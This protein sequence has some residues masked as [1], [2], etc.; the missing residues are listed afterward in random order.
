MTAQPQDKNNMTPAEYLAMERGSLD[1]KHEFFDGEIFA[2]VGAKINHVRI[3]A[4]LTGELRNHFK[5]N[6]SPCEVLPNDMRVK[7]ENGYVYPDIVISCGEV[8]FED[9]EFDTLINP[10]VI[11]EILSDST[12]AFDRGKKFAYYRAISTLQEYL[13]VSQD[14]YHVEQFIRRDNGKWEYCSYKG[15]DQ[16]LKIESVNCELPLSEIYWGV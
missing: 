11:M 9:N 16:A 4:N 2:M 10:V 3:N 6:K 12:E 8:K 14:E 13:L 1:I 15:I 7:I 5:G